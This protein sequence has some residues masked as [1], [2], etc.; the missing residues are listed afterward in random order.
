M[1]VKEQKSIEFDNQ[2]KAVFAGNLLAQAILWRAEKP[3]ARVKRVFMHGRY[4][5]VSIHGKK[6]HIHR[7]IAEWE[8]VGATLP[9]G[10]SVHHKDGDRLNARLDNLEVINQADHVRRHLGGN[11]QEPEFVKRRIAA[12]IKKRWP[13]RRHEN[14][15]LLK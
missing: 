15:E 1:I 10:M 8:I 6:Y 7:L 13:N 3:V 9:R 11:K 14:P 2:A 4:P 12:S 5:A